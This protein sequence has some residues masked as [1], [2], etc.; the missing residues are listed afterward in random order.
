MNFRALAESFIQSDI[1]LSEYIC[2]KKEKQYI[3]VVTVMRF[4]ETSGKHLQLV[5]PL[6]VYKKDRQNKTLQYNAKCY[7]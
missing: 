7:F 2:Q 6:P 3:A 5:N 1:Q 4:I